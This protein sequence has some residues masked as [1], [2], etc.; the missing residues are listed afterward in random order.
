MAKRR[1]VGAENISPNLAAL[2][3]PIDDLTLDP[4]NVRLHSD[5]N[6][7]AIKASLRK[8]GQ[9]K[10]IVVTED[11][12]V[13][14][15]NGTL[16]VASDLGWESIAAV[17]FQGTENEATAY[18]IADNRTSELGEWD[19]QGFAEQISGPLKDFDINVLGFAEGE[20]A[21]ILRRLDFG[22]NKVESEGNDGP[23]AGTGG[24]VP[25]D[26]DGFEFAHACPRCHFEFN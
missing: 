12:V 26:V 2:A 13:I 11:G 15:G 18:A 25:V 22:G 1:K 6:L 17:T 4:A 10:P 3:R 24:A 8:F 14:A 7:E 5:R 23:S 9:Q 20:I 19:W 16:R 21:G